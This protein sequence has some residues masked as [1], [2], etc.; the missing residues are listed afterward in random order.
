VSVVAVSSLLAMIAGATGCSGG[1]DPAVTETPT[2]EPEVPVQPE[3]PL[4][5]LL[6]VQAHFKMEGKKPIPQPAKLMIW[7]TDGTNWWGEELLD[8]DSNVWHK[9]MPYN[10]GFLTIGAQSAVLKHWTPSGAGWAAA[11]LWR[12]QWDG[13]FNRL[14]D[15]EIGDV[16]G[17]PGDEIVLATHDVGVVAVGTE[18][19]GTFTFTE[20]DKKPDTFVHE[21]EIGDVDGDGKPEFYATPSDR[22][23]VSGASQPGAVV[24]YDFDGAAWK[25]SPVVSW[26]DTHAKEILVTDTDGDGVDELYVAKEGVKATGS[27]ALKAPVQVIRYT[28]GADAWVPCVIATLPG[29]H[30]LR[31]LVPG[32]VDG[33][34]A[35][36]ILAPGYKTG[37]W[38]LEP[39]TD[40]SC[41]W[42]P[43][44]IDA[45]SGGFEHATHVAD[46][47]GDGKLEIYVA[48]DNNKELRRYVHEGGSYTRST[49]WTMPAHHLT[50]NIQ[51]A[52]L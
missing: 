7:R 4:R 9:A 11:E 49:V 14:R 29:E 16:D 8:P 50:W 1:S 39:P 45:K 35:V 43:V 42:S 41:A 34:G 46:M 5:A 20:L 18:S 10:G 44:Q 15:I 22:N 25:R 28:K 51:D 38:V 6:V 27:K 47:D 12:V 36:E 23:N 17:K 13:K 19:G 2:A 30:Q 40:D 37:L 24:R 21:I 26:T 32:D 31:F 33:D 3:G 48:S 52:S